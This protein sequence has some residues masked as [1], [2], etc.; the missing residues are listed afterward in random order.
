MGHVLCVCCRYWEEKHSGGML[1][2]GSLSPG[3]RAL[4]HLGEM[5]QR[6]LFHFPVKHFKLASS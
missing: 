2:K 4:Q 1:L 5:I 6:D 3:N